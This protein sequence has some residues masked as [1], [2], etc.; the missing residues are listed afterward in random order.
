MSPTD[1]GRPR[2]SCRLA[3]RRL[4]RVESVFAQMAQLLRAGISAAEALESLASREPARRLRA[5]LADTAVH[6]AHGWPLAEALGRWPRLFPAFAVALV[7]AGE[8]SGHV[9]AAC[10]ETAEDLNRQVALERR[11]AWPRLWYG[12]AVMLAVLSV[13]FVSYALRDLGAEATANVRRMLGYPAWAAL[14]VL[15]WLALVA[16]GVWLAGAVWRSAALAPLRDPLELHTPVV[17]RLTRARALR[18]WAQAWEWLQRAGVPPGTALETAAVASGNL[19]TAR[20]LARAAE[21]AAG[22]QSLL[23]ALQATRMLPREALAELAT[24]EQAGE[25]ETTFARLGADFREQ[26][27]V[28]A[29]QVIGAGIALAL[30]VTT[31]V[32]IAAA[33]TGFVIYNDAL[34]RAFQHALTGKESTP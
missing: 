27:E 28:A 31:V 19:L 30:A 9:P 3:G 4:Q 1:P 21:D 12:T 22:G 16:L 18:R 7:R 17:G 34:M 8:L 32:V 20:A 5:A 10:A 25:L 11:L 6:V 23:A 15:P 13:S 29:R 33:A 26:E 24:G 14:H 2:P